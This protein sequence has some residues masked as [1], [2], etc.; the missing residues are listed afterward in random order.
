MGSVELIAIGNHWLPYI[1][2][3]SQLWTGIVL[4]NADCIFPDIFQ[5]SFFL[6]R[7]SAIKHPFV[8]ICSDKLRYFFCNFFFYFIFVF[9][10]IFIIFYH[11]F[12]FSFFSF[13]IILDCR[14]LQYFSTYRISIWRFILKGYWNHSRWLNCRFF[15]SSYIF[16]LVDFSLNFIL[17]IRTYICCIFEMI[18]WLMKAIITINEKYLNR[19]NEQEQ[20][21]YER[22]TNILQRA[23][24]AV[25]KKDGKKKKWSCQEFKT[26]MKKE[27][28]LYRFELMFSTFSHEPKLKILRV[29]A[30]SKSNGYD[31][32]LIF[33][34]NVWR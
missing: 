21:N 14:C 31:L 3:H 10:F 13:F 23:Q 1:S 4:M 12:F 16:F 11:F 30:F 20:T 33:C 2:Q 18:R 25:R 17:V 9:A 22:P 6:I 27:K 24:N 15:P 5:S 32:V 28:S 7:F 29:E 8:Q 26:A 34:G 19:I